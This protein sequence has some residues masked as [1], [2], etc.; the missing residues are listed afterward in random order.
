M[1]GF[2]P[3]YPTAALCFISSTE[4]DFSVSQ[5]AILNADNNARFVFKAGSLPVGEYRVGF[6]CEGLSYSG[7]FRLDATR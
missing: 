7:T 3:Q 5:I 2:T 1:L 6:Y 4:E